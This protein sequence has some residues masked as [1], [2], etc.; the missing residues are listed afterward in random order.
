[1]WGRKSGDTS[2]QA[3]QRE[4]K[5]GWKCKRQQ[6]EQ[7]GGW[8]QQGA[9]EPL[10]PPSWH[11]PGPPPGPHPSLLTEGAPLSLPSA[12]LW[13][14]SE[15][16]P[17]HDYRSLSPPRPTISSADEKTKA[18]RGNRSKPQSLNCFCKCFGTS[19]ERKVSKTCK[20]INR[21]WSGE[22]RC[23]N[24]PALQGLREAGGAVF[25]MSVKWWTSQAMG[26][27]QSHGDDPVL[28][29]LSSFL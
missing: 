26:P 17:S 23:P 1:M 25:N 7:E 12:L 22:Q 28:T 11:L 8:G 2:L 6:T 15:E 14:E 5:S 29:I 21:S 27:A 19:F 20:S 18:Q 13:E 9:L 24:P 4:K 10:P 16:G 3:W